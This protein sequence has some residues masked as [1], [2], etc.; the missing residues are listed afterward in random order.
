MMLVGWL[1]LGCALLSAAGV[2]IL[3]ALD[4][5]RR[6][7]SRRATPSAMRRLLVLAV[8][9]PG[10]ALGLAG[11]WSDFLIW[12]GAAALLGWGIAALFNVRWRQPHE[13]SN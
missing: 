12:V 7:Y 4:P 5:K 8:F 2:V 10:V 6:R 9:I 1:G 11:R 3:A 13:K